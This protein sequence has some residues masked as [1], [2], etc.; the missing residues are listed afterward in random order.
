MRQDACK[1]AREALKEIKLC[2]LMAEE[3]IAQ[4]HERLRG[5]N[6]SH[7][8]RERILMSLSASLAQYSLEQ[9]RII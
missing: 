5:L 3:A 8:E 7:K 2:H 6:I 9:D 1:E 4:V